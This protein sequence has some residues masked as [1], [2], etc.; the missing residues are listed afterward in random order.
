MAAVL[1][2]GSDLSTHNLEYLHVVEERLNNRTRKT[3]GWR[4]PNEVHAAAMA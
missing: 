1:P 4:T 2:E 3:L